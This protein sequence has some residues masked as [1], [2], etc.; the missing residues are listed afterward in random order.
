MP[1]T[2][3]FVMEHYRQTGRETDALYAGTA[4]GNEVVFTAIPEY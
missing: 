2:A 3:Q 4:N 1:Y